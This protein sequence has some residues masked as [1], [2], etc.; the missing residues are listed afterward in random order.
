[1][2]TVKEGAARE[3]IPE[4]T[5]MAVCCEVIDL[6]MHKQEYN[7]EVKPSKRE[8]MIRWEIPEITYK[9]EEG[10]EFT[11]TVSKRLRLVYNDKSG[12]YKLLRGWCPGLLPKDMKKEGFDLTLLIGNGA[13][14]TVTH[15]PRKDGTGM[16]EEFSFAPLMK[17]VKP[18]KASHMIV[19][20]L[21]EASA[22]EKMAFL[23][24]WI[25]SIIK[26]GES[27]EQMT[28]EPLPFDN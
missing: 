11:K 20:D 21:D 3:L 6:G 7:G 2:L 28:A 13:Q 27:Y 15:V 24:E 18:P 16:M 4:D 22:L 26:E 23:P 1:M 12:L 17:G 19:F 14:L 5:Y 9:N 10:E 8:V 25:Q